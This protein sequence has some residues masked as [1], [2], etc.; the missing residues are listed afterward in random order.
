[1]GQFWGYFGKIR[2]FPQKFG[3]IRE[4][5]GEIR[6]IPEFVPWTRRKFDLT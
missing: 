4:F 2:D 3:E 1:L 5:W 6:E